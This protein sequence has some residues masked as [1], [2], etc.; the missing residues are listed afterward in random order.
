[1]AQVKSTP[2][3]N[4]RVKDS[5]KR[6]PSISS[7]KQKKANIVDYKIFSTETDTIHLDT[8]LSLK[9]E[10][11]F[12]YLR[13]DNFNLIQFS[14]IG[15]T[16]NTLSY[17][18][19][20]KSI[21]PFFG[22][23]SKHFNYL[24]TEDIF[25]YQVPTPL[26]ELQ[27]K[28]A[29]EQGQLLDAFFTV[30]TSKNF[31]F[32]IAYK[33]L[34]SLGK[35]QHILSSTGNF[36][37]TAN[38]T[39]KSNRYKSNIHIVTQD[40]LNEENGGLT[41]DGVADFES[42][43]QEFL[44]RSVFDPHFEN[45]E[46]KLVGKRFYINHQYAIK[47]AKD[48]TQNELKLRNIIEF[49][50]KFF[51]YDQLVADEEFFG[52][53]FSTLI[54][55]KNTLENFNTSLELLFNLN[56]IGDIALGL[57]YNNYNYGYDNLVQVDG[58]IIPNRIK[59]D[60][61]SFLGTLNTTIKDFRLKSDLKLN[62]SGDIDGYNF[63]SEVNYPFNKNELSI[64]L[65]L[66]S[67]LPSFNTLLYQSDYI[68]YNWYNFDN[69][70]NV[71]TQALLVKLNINKYFELSGD[72]TRINNY[73]YFSNNEMS[74]SNLN[75][76]PKQFDGSID[77]YRLKVSNEFSF[78]K[79]TL[80]NTVL[81]QDTLEE[82]SIF[83]TPDFIL[84]NTLYFSDHIF[85]KAMFLQTGI[86]FNYFSE[87]SMNAYNPLLGEFFAQSSQQLGGFPRLDFFIN[88]KVR[89]TRIFLKAEHFNSAFTG[90]NY[91]SA[92]N[93]PYRDFSVRFGLVWNFFL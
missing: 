5:I 82:N 7:S 1:M 16:Y 36:R 31:N 19:E 86:T 57:N 78:G 68:D 64:S 67:V 56:K 77:Y 59:G 2:K 48:S 55:D 3:R 30:N 91:F 37:V 65:N 10:Y 79:F 6:A 29:F 89:Q 13:K 62:V 60:N 20:R 73:T 22:A 74:T 93:Y 18:F 50:D 44:D 66:Q 26:T 32:S 63:Y 23:S 9:K 27:Y 4:N 38:Y 70:K 11:K 42:G 46:S 69:F 40:I 41:E 28:S 33:G 80:D 24:K 71:E 47:Q 35:Y 83:N 53:S 14:N 61:I 81:Y 25:Y 45:A 88:A 76:T 85:K 43:S 92:P 72:Y 12:N 87:Y 39:S 90:Y 15:Q 52:N 51:R 54:R 75:V 21:V 58:E 17:D 8:T 49:E 84:R 34:R